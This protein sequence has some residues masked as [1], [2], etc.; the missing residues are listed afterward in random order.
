[1]NPN[2]K[3]FVPSKQ[4]KTPKFENSIPIRT[5]KLEDTEPLPLKLDSTKQKYDVMAPSYFPK[6]QTT[7]LTDTVMPLLNLPCLLDDKFY[8][9]LNLEKIIHDGTNEN[10]FVLEDDIK[11]SLLEEQFNSELCLLDDESKKQKLLEFELILIKDMENI[12][13]TYQHKKKSICLVPS[14]HVQNVLKQRKPIAYK[15]IDYTY[16]SKWHKFV[17]NH[18]DKFEIVKKNDDGCCIKLCYIKLKDDVIEFT[19]CENTGN[20]VLLEMLMYAMYNATFMNVDTNKPLGANG[21][22]TLEQF[23]EWYK[24]VNNLQDFCDNHVLYEIDDIPKC[25]TKKELLKIV[26]NYPDRVSILN[27]SGKIRFLDSLTWK[28]I[29]NETPEYETIDFSTKEILKENINYHEIVLKMDYTT[30]EKYNELANLTRNFLLDK[31]NNPEEGSVPSERIQNYIKSVNGEL[32]KFI[33]GLYFHNQWHKFI[34]SNKLFHLFFVSEDRRSVWRIR[35]V[36][37]KNWRKADE[38]EHKKLQIREQM[39][40]NIVRNYLRSNGTSKIDDVLEHV[41]TLK[42]LNMID[43]VPFRGDFCRFLRRNS[44][45]F[46]VVG[47][48]KNKDLE[49]TVRNKHYF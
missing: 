16:S 40:V 9:D 36:E 49:F 44:E 38:I 11:Q 18:D 31:I 42:D 32:Y 1:M 12:I 4:M 33:V 35:L 28:P 13:K 46:S 14:E 19:K 45:F 30:K 26:K 15:V 6:N 29:K 25:V 5:P 17:M 37:H 20:I 3:S 43:K 10:I 2:A 41:Q 22:I 24:N 48:N 23:M 8:E 34:L 47:S 21:D 7:H 39:L 27:D